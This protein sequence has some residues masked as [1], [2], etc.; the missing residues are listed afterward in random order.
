MSFL[1]VQITFPG[2]ITFYIFMVHLII[3]FLVVR[4]RNNHEVLAEASR[5]AEFFLSEYAWTQEA[6][7]YLSYSAMCLL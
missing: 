5:I 4:V 6:T 7:Q 3:I 1:Q 2:L